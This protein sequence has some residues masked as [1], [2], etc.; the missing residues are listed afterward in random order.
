MEIYNFKNWGFICL[1]LFWV[2]ECFLKQ[3]CKNIID[4]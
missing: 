2:L 1:D 4:T 3:L